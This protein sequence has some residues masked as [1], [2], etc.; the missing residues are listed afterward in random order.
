MK[1]TDKH[2]AGS[3][4]PV[5]VCNLAVVPKAPDDVTK[6]EVSACLEEGRGVSAIEVDGALVRCG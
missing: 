3:G 2:A 4:L 6:H 1:A 5:S